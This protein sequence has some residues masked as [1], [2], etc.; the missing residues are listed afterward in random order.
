MGKSLFFVQGGPGRSRHYQ[1]FY[2]GTYNR[3]G[4]CPSG[5]N[6]WIYSTLPSAPQKCQGVVS[7][8]R[9]KGGWMDGS[10]VHFG[11][12]CDKSKSDQ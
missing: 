7:S 12:P 8:V 6:G 3:S 5:I 1:L 4:L 11:V 10:T 9:G 2:I